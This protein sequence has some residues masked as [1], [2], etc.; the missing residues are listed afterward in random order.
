MIAYKKIRDYKGALQHGAVV[1]AGLKTKHKQDLSVSS[2]TE[3]K[4]AA[5]NLAALP[6][7]LDES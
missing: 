7:E 6:L 4:N 5:L 2:N 3:T 1:V